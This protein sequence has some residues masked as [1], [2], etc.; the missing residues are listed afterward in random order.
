VCSQ[1]TVAV[2]AAKAPTCTE[3]GLTEGAH[4]SVCGEIITAQT[5]VGALGHKDGNADNVCD[6]APHAFVKN[7][8]TVNTYTFTVADNDPFDP[9]NLGSAGGLSVINHAT[10]GKFYESSYGK[11]FTITIVAPEAMNIDL[12]M[13]VTARYDGVTTDNTVVEILLDGKSLGVTR[14]ANT[15]ILPTGEGGAAW[16]VVN[17]VKMRY[18]TIALHEGKNVITITR[19]ETKSNSTNINIAGIAVDAPAPISLG[20][21]L[22][23]FTV[24]E[25][26]PFS[27]AN[28]G[29]A[30][31][32]SV[33][34]NSSY[35]KYYESSY[36][37]TFSFT[38][39]VDKD[40]TADFYLL[41]TTRFA[42]V[43]KTASVTE[44]LIDGQAVGVVRADGNVTNIGGWNTASATRDLFA[45]LTLTKGT[46]VIS[47]KRADAVADANNFNIAGIA[48]KSNSA[49]VKLGDGK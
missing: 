29:D 41:T 33:I 18:A 27:N 11:T 44:I 38:I 8:A 17:A 3:S 24:A 12:C 10:Y 4:C 21:S 45:T 31:G 35:G 15:D 26:N 30:D 42:G 23:T 16:N 1:H 48:I 20:T 9:T 19:T 6:N 25:N 49:V 2:D 34:N 47:F 22:Y 46:H 43:S 32:L 5:V 28:G 39:T 40:T 13:L 14:A 7:D 36:G 37:K